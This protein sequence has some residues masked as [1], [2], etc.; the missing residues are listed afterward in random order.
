MIL[1]IPVD[2]FP[3]VIHIMATSRLGVAV[4]PRVLFH[5]IGKKNEL[6]WASPHLKRV[7]QSI[8]WLESLLGKTCSSC[9]LNILMYYVNHLG[10]IDDLIMCQ[11]LGLE[12]K[13]GITGYIVP[14]FLDDALFAYYQPVNAMKRNRY[15]MRKCH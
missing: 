5:T 10:K 1:I 3:N 11:C 15:Y 7:F 2:I 14:L 9:C 8:W 13:N 12:G 6:H 4:H